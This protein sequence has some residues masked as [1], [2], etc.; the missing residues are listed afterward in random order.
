MFLTQA[1]FFLLFAAAC[2]NTPRPQWGGE[3]AV[4]AYQTGAVMDIG[5][6]SLQYEHIAAMAEA[7]FNVAMAEVDFGGH[8]T[9]AQQAK[10]YLDRA[11]EVNMK[12][13]AMDTK[14][15]IPI[16]EYRPESYGQGAAD[17][18]NIGLYKD[19]PAFYGLCISDEPFSPTADTEAVI[20]LL[21]LKVGEFRETFPGKV[22]F[23]NLSVW[24]K[25]AIEPFVKEVQPDFLSYDEYCILSDKSIASSYL[26]NL[27]KIKRIAMGAGIPA[28]DTLLTVGHFIP[29]G[30]RYA[31]PDYNTLRWQVAC[32]QTFGYAGFYHY[33]GNPD[34]NYG[35]DAIIKNGQ[36][37][38]LYDDI[39]SVHADVR[40][41]EHVYLSFEWEGIAAIESGG[42]NELFFL[43][44]DKTAKDK[45]PGIKKIANSQDMLVGIF[46]DA[47][48]NRGYMLTNGTNPW[49]AKSASAEI[50]FDGYDGVQ[51]WEKGA[52]RVVNLD[53]DGAAVIELEPG[54][55]KFLIP[56][57]RA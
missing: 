29:S 21:K 5:L 11:A 26:A 40:A 42:L 47:D 36:K 17:K 20:S 39:K 14:F 13:I 16:S 35:Y 1:A 53:K 41:W 10:K 24:V 27:A 32:T 8:Y 4:P 18:S 31:T 44:P 22:P 7:G 30:K 55:G 46:K 25:E 56:L 3:Y 6:W 38:Q 23:I 54:E 15:C 49:Q 28:Y 34:P 37:T 19:H 51:V 48:G 45:I 33:N 43:I 50:T 9:T 2:N 57:K 52:P 12:C